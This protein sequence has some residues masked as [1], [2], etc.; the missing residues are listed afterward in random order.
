M[1]LDD[2]ERVDAIFDAFLDQA[3]DFQVERVAE[4]V[5][6]ANQRFEAVVHLAAQA[7]ARDRKFFFDRFA[8]EGKTGCFFVRVGHFRLLSVLW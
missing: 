7:V 4:G 6:F 3:F 1:G 2:A 8:T 5:H